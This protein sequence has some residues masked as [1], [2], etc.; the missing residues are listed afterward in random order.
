MF[1]VLQMESSN[2]A[3]PER[4]DVGQAIALW[5]NAGVGRAGADS[6]NGLW[7]PPVARMR[8]RVNNPFRG[9]E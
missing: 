1:G 8:Q 7:C 2:T 3:T 9:E 6:G 4:L 5:G